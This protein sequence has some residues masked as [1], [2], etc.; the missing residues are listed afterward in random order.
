MGGIDFD[1]IGDAAGTPV[2]AVGCIRDEFN[3]TSR[4]IALLARELNM[5]GL[6]EV[7]LI[8]SVFSCFRPCLDPRG[9]DASDQTIR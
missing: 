9:Q 1:G 8:I 2:A 5:V 4:G 3:L 7:N 6:E